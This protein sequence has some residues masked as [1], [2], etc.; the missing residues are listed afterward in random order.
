MPNGVAVIE[1]PVV[2]LFGARAVHKGM[3]SKKS[4]SLI[5]PDNAIADLR[6]AMV[7]ELQQSYD[8]LGCILDKITNADA[9]EEVLQLRKT[10]EHIAEEHGIELIVRV[11][12][13]GGN[14]HDAR[15]FGPTGT[16]QTASTRGN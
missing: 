9:R 6:A 10:A 7:R 12:A 5:V 15:V 13:V 3:G 2:H 8:Y 16:V 4:S 1:S 11:S 14:S